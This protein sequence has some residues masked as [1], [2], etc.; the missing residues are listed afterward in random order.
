MFFRIKV[1]SK[2]GDKV[3]V[4]IPLALAKAFVDSDAAMPQ[5]QGKDVLSNVDFKQIFA[6]IEQGVIGKMVEVESGDGDFVE[7]WV[8]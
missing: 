2:D 1:L 8:E 3:K 6:L 7:I 5:I 4:N